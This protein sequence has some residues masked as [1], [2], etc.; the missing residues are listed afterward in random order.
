MP[1]APWIWAF[2]VRRIQRSSPVQ[3]RMRAPSSP[4]ISITRACLR[5]PRPPSLILFRHGDWSEADV[6]S[7]LSVLLA[8]LSEADIARSIQ[9]VDR[10]RVWSRRLPIA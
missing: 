6:I 7:R 4:P 9:V 8:G 3:N 10:D 1:F 5:L 2:V